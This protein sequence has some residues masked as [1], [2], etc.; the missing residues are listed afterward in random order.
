[1]NVFEEQRLAAVDIV[2]AS[3]VHKEMLAMR[4][5]ELRVKPI[6]RSIPM[7]LSREDAP[8]IVRP[9]SRERSDVAALN[10]VSPSGAGLSSSA[11]ER[12]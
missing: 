5:T 2:N 8:D 10:I 7:R 12:L 1:M 4:G 11:R 6:S 9:Q 3:E